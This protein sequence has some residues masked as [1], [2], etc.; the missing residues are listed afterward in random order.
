MG[1]EIVY[2]SKCA[3]RLLGSDFEKGKAFRIGDRSACAKCAREILPTLPFQEAEALASR[4]SEAQSRR[5][6]SPVLP[7]IRPSST[8]IP[9]SPANETPRRATASR[10]EAAPASEKKSTPAVPIVIGAGVLVLAAVA[11]LVLGGGR[12]SP[13]PGG[14]SPEPG[15]DDPAQV[16]SPRPDPRPDLKPDPRPGPPSHRRLRLP[17]PK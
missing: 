5:A 9:I 10:G 1:Q 12:T 7:A 16:A 11:A 15:I 14:R 3:E 4:L 2:C 13:R 8:T 17:S 6:S